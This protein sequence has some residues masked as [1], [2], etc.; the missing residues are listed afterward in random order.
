M[1]CPKCE[2]EY[3][4]GISTCSDC[5]TELI[6]SEEFEKNLIHHDDWTTIY[7]TDALY[8]AEMIKANLKGADIESIILSQKDKNFPSSGDL[9]VI[10][11]LVKKA[12]AG[13]A[14][15]IISEIID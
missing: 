5:G 15:K 2:T 6:T 9:S 12:D 10:K 13:D 11:I 1:I 14:K 7:S 4:E 3:V 8:E